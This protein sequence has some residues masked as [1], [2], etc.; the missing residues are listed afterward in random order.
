M[1]E[2]SN[3]I[4]RN[5]FNLLTKMHN[6]WSANLDASLHHLPP[7][8]LHLQR[9]PD[10]PD[11]KNRVHLFSASKNIIQ[12][13]DST[14]GDLLIT[15]EEGSGKTIL[16][17]ELTLALL[18]RAITDKEYPFPVILQPLK[19]VERSFSFL[20]WL[21]QKIQRLSIT[22]WVTK[23]LQKQF[24]L[25][26]YICQSLLNDGHILLFI[27]GLDAPEIQHSR[28]YV[29]ALVAYRRQHNIPLVICSENTDEF[30]DFQFICPIAIEPLTVQ[31][32]DD[33]LLKVNG[34]FA[35]LRSILQQDA[36]VQQKATNPY[37]L[38]S[39]M[40]AFQDETSNAGVSSKQ[41]MNTVIERYVKHK[42]QPQGVNHPYT[43]HQ[44][45]LAQLA[46]GQIQQLPAK[47]LLSVK[48]QLLANRI[49]TVCTVVGILFISGTLFW[50]ALS[51]F[52][53][54]PLI[55]IFVEAVILFFIGL[56][57]IIAVMLRAMAFG[58][59]RRIAVSNMAVTA[60]LMLSIITFPLG[61]IL[62]EGWK[63]L[64][65]SLLFIILII[66]DIPLMI[67]LA[68]FLV[69]SFQ[70]LLLYIS[71]FWNKRPSRDIQAFLNYA[72]EIG[73]IKKEDNKYLFFNQQIFDY[74]NTI[75]ESKL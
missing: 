63:T 5:I 18:D 47:N 57:Y 62:P 54:I 7:L 53:S 9:H 6:Y 15:G 64:P 35:S 24:Q 11:V 8:D 17:L 10:F 65:A 59:E 32:V 1:G 56:F 52:H 71:R 31:Q 45:W 75:D 3:R 22:D 51:V 26:P 25:P 12:L 23:T 70:S 46:K 37:R 14:G 19:N 27:D 73:I 20:S 21:P 41:L 28:W 68:L 29:D 49:M 33:Y 44:L 61:F 39:L 30:K 13:Y 58:S 38:H 16:L 2:F 69:K 67:I 74:F 50:R 66:L 4:E 55:T 60:G 34:K 36:Q 72:V 48:N 42:L 43:V 40:L